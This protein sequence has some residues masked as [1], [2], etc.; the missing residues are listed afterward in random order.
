MNT[1]SF[2]YIEIVIGLLIAWYYRANLKHNVYISII[3]EEHKQLINMINETIVL[4]TLAAYID[5]YH[6]KYSLLLK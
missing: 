4:K 2:I 3:N 1:K 5:R 6:S